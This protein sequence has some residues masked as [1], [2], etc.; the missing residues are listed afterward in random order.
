MHHVLSHVKEENWKADSTRHASED[1]F[2][3]GT[4]TGSDVFEN[5]ESIA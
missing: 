3:E 2:N 5:R 1:L 4:I